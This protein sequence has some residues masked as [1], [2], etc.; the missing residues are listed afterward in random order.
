[1][2]FDKQNYREMLRI[3]RLERMTIITMPGLYHVQLERIPLLPIPQYRIVLSWD[4]LA[5]LSFESRIPYSF[6]NFITTPEL[7][8]PLYIS[9]DIYHTQIT[10]YSLQTIYQSSLS[11]LSDCPIRPDW[12]FREHLSH[13]LP[14]EMI[15]YLFRSIRSE[16]LI[17][18]YSAELMLDTLEI[19]IKWFQGLGSGRPS[20]L[21]DRFQGELLRHTRLPQI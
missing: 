18:D 13:A 11:D 2:S 14:T 21:Y 1:V 6:T 10:E 4:L 8:G 12:C 20:D 5:W 9:P 15:L 7:S 19:I 3:T 17:C 16:C